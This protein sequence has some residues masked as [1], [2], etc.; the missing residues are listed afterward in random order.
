MDVSVKT[1]FPEGRYCYFVTVDAT[2]DGN[3]VFPYVFGPSYN[4]VV[5]IWNLD[6]N[7]IQQNIPTGVV[8][9]RDPYENVD[10]DVERAP[11]ASTNA[12]TLE[13]GDVLLFE[14][15]DENRDGIISQD[16]TDDPDQI[17][18]E[19]PLQLFDYFPSVR[20]DS[21]VDIEVET[22]TKFE[23]ASVTGFTIED[24]GTSYQVDDILIFDNAGTDGTGVSARVSKVNGEVVSSYTFENIEDT[25]YGVLTTSVSH[26][27][28]PGDQIFVD[29]T[30]VM[31]STNKQF[32]VRQ[33][34]GIEDIVIN[35]TGSGYDDEIP[36]TIKIDG[37]GNS[38]SLQAV[39]SQVGSI[40]QVNIINSG[41]SYTK[42]PRV[43]ISHP[44]IFKKADYYVSLLS[45]QNYVKINDSYINSD[46]ELYVCG[47]TL[48]ANNNEV[49]FVA[50]FSELGI[51]EWE[52]SLES[53]VGET[54]TEFI[55][56]DVRGDAIWLVGENKPNA[57][58][59]AVYNPDVFLAKYTQSEDG[60]SATLDFQKGYAGISGST[61][62]DYVTSIKAYSD[63]RYI[64]GGYTNTNSANP[65]DAF[66][67]SIDST[68]GFAAK[69]KIATAT[70]SEKLTDLIVLGDSVYFIMEV[71]N[72][73]SATDVRLSLGKAT[74][75]TSIITVDWT[76]E[77]SNTLYS[78]LDTSLVIDEFNEIYVT[79]T[80]RLK[81]NNTTK[82]GFW[83][84]K[85]DTDGD[86]IWNYRYA[87]PTGNTIQAANRT[88]I[89]IFGELNVA[90]TRTDDTT[91]YKTVDTVK[92]DYD[93]KMVKQTNNAFT[94]NNI[95]GL[96]V[97]ALA[98]DN[99][100]DVYPMG[101]T[102]WNRNEFIFPFSSGETTDIT[103]HYTP[104][105]LS[106]GESVRFLAELLLFR[107]IKLH[108]LHLGKMLQSRCPQHN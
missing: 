35:Q 39:V 5:D 28:I 40:E 7:A 24:P 37:D 3:P 82:D 68:G 75:G 17:F 73:S 54:Y 12:L 64:I 49:A 86:L 90:Y 57:S 29:Y 22:I 48:D 47:K 16:E 55:R 101:Q 98:V 93:G 84:G 100:G 36:P 13:N 4:S 80:T 20:L 106:T 10:I 85:F 103:A 78:Y 15:E 2:E 21:K 43:I 71:A 8:R 72:N 50:K 91:G 27:I 58:I 95:E 74:I 62:A 1:E 42:D 102:S 59:L 6:E 52:K 96:N 88:V 38:A 14:V 70:G 44:Q 97:Y 77:I 33:L 104:T 69:R 65:F 11:N 81:S 9:F 19:S 87:A 66:I 105:F 60:L 107:V 89:D 83:V 51:K 56:M 61:R 30:P 45:N 53:Q 79:A 23:D 76:K 99:S 32:V 108:L 94:I 25:Y 46:K 26:N 18:E 34:K 63:S 67:A 92:I 41:S 31:D